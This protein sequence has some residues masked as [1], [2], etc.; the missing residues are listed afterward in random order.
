MIEEVM[1]P[2]A[3]SLVMGFAVC[4]LRALSIINDT[5]AKIFVLLERLGRPAPGLMLPD[6]KT[7]WAGQVECVLCNSPAT[8][9]HKHGLTPLCEEHLKMVGHKI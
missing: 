9:L 3:I 2:L 7:C 5:V 4:V 6:P 8:G 1:V